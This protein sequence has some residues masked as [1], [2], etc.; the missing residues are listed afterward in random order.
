ML[1]PGIFFALPLNTPPQPVS[2]RFA[3]RHCVAESYRSLGGT[4][5]IVCAGTSD[6]CSASFLHTG[7][8]TFLPQYNI[9]YSLSPDDIESLIPRTIVA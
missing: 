3:P 5:T 9:F 7:S 4:V 1:R 2:Y 6:A 8:L